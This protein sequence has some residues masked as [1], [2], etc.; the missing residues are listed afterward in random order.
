MNRKGCDRKGSLPILRYSPR[1]YQ[2]GLRKTTRN[3]TV[4]DLLIE[5]VNQDGALTTQS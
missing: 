5:I 4:A 1:I 3:Y 2:E